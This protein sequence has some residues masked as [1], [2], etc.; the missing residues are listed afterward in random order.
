LCLSFERISAR[1]L[2]Y[3]NDKTV[4]ADWVTE[5]TNG[6]RNFPYDDDYPFGYEILGKVVNHQ[7]RQINYTGKRLDY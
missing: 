2:R 6:M 1:T 7:G 5:N 3:I 4:V